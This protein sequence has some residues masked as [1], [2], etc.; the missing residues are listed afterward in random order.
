MK[1][2]IIISLLVGFILVIFPCLS[3]SRDEIVEPVKFTAQEKTWL[4]SH[5]V[6][7]LA[8]ESNYPPFIF[9]D[10][11][12]NVQGISV[13]YLALL[14]K[15]LGLKFS[16][17]SPRPL[18]SI[19]EMAQKKEVDVI[20]SL[21]KTSQREIY[22]AFTQSYITVPTIIIARQDDDR[23]FSLPEM[24]GMN[25]A[26]GEGY[27]VQAFL[28]NNYPQLELRGV[29]DDLD[30][31]R[32][33]SFGE[34]DAVVMDIASASYFIEKEGIVN[35]RVAGQV[36]YFYDLSLAVR[37][38]FPELVQILNKGF[39]AIDDHER[40]EIH[41][42]WVQLEVPFAIKKE[43]LF[44]V[45]LVFGVTILFSCFVWYWNRKLHKEIGE[46]KKIEQALKESYNELRKA[47]A[48]LEA[49]FRLSELATHASMEKLMQATI[50]EAEI[51]TESKIGFFHFVDPDQE[52]LILQTWSSNTLAT[53]CTAEGKG[54]HYPISQAGVWVD[55][56]HQR[57][58]VIH[59]DYA[60]LP[61]KKG[62]PEGHAPV[63]GELTLPIIRGE[64]VK[65]IIGVGNKET[66]YTE[67]DVKVVKELASFSIDLVERKQA[68]E[69][70]R[71]SKQEWEQTFDAMNDIVT[72]QD[73]EMRIIKANKAAHETLQ[74]ES[75]G[76]EG[77]YCYEVFRGADHPCPECPEFVTIDTMKT[78]SADISHAN[79]GKMFH[80]TCSPI[81][82]ENGEFTHIVHLAKD[83]TEQKKMEA[84]LFQAHKMEAIG[85]LAGGI[86]HDFNNILAAII[87]YADMANDDLPE[88]SHTKNYISQVLNAGNRAKELVKQI[89]TFS[90]KGQEKQ[91]PLQPYPIIK[92]GLKL[93]RASLPTTID[94]QEQIDPDC[95]SIFSNPTNVHQVL[96]NLCTNALHAMEDEKGILTVQL[97]QVELRQV[98]LAGIADV[99]PGLF[100]ELRVSD[101][102]RGLDKATVE[103]IFE[104]YFTT[105][106]IDKGSGMGLALVH[107]IVQGCGGFIKVESN[108]DE[109]STFHVYFPA[110][111]EKV[112]EVEEEKEV[113][114]LHGSERILV[115]DDEEVIVGVYQATL[116]R[117]GYKVTPHCSSE[118]ALAVFQA[119]PDS[120][121]LIITDQTM[122]H[123]SG[124]E[125]A[126]KVLKI[127]P[128]IPIILCT[129]YSSMISEKQAQEIG[130]QKFVMKPVIGTDLAIITREVLDK[131]KT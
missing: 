98:D 14:E 46:R 8:P 130:I 122:P 27:G 115:V 101:T 66:S 91:Q 68:E 25:V 44:V 126:K 53:M 108:P 2:K 39:A 52:R 96:L 73:K 24:D 10:S 59:Q 5:P 48:L 111:E 26:V 71:K 51:F 40:E 84:E 41:S 13:D 76:L 74:V 114:L 1:E 77:K 95:G 6:I 69:T 30:G 23:T 7:R 123:L 86:A 89:L 57:R 72:I 50:D 42:K 94:I 85:T 55:C 80:V 107:G 32:K 110:I 37:K 43:V 121:D 82:D 16:F 113:P 92:E 60:S 125:L 20:T 93:M 100:V 79:L 127:R 128:D 28:D 119:S 129:G 21:K 15:K 45:F 12:G 64:L 103:R 88:S 104:P 70:I 38:D 22:L 47:E 49:R 33:L 99:S 18:A 61:H 65:A 9:A 109:G 36:D 112:A 29:P 106:G 19:L 3:S 116:E 97:T 102:G 81:L 17:L 67:E 124:S 118:K 131:K 34:V 31:L 105:K 62:I 90:R 83:I 78:Y 63:V 75:G 120:F 35:L 117:L 4:E 87:G 58:P 56:F 54:K 11:S